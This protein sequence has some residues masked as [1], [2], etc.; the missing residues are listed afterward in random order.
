MGPPQL[1]EALVLDPDHEDALAGLGETLL[2]FGQTSGALEVVPPGSSELGYQDDIELARSVARSSRRA[3]GRGERIFS[4]PPCSRY[5]TTPKRWRW[6]L[7]GAPARPRRRRDAHVAARASA[8]PDMW[9]PASISATYSTIAASTKPPSI[10]SIAWPRRPL[11]RTRHLAHHRAEEE[12]LPSCRRRSGAP[13]V[14]RAPQQLAGEPDSI[15]EML[16]EDRAVRKRRSG[17]RGQGQLEL[18][19]ALLADPGEHKKA[20]GSIAPGDRS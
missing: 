18:F 10:I 8:R 12:H 7:H 13:A 11:G 14:G 1:Q 19:G 17:A 2:K 9:K 15:D 5:P 16:G 6:S 3:H 4:T 20:P